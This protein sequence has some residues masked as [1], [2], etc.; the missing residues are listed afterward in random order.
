MKTHNRSV[1]WCLGSRLVKWKHTQQCMLENKAK[2]PTVQ[3]WLIVFRLLISCWW[4][5]GGTHL[6]TNEKT[7]S[8]LFVIRISL[9][10]WYL[11]LL[12]WWSNFKCHC[13]YGLIPSWLAIVTG[14]GSRERG[15]GGGGGGQWYVCAPPFNP[16]FL[17][18]TWIICLYKTDREYYTSTRWR[19]FILQRVVSKT[20]LTSES[21]LDTFRNH[22]L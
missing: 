4:L 14:V 10:I 3:S 21:E 17:F 9:I 5:L 12:S 13:L 2:Q 20:Y 22:E 7:R 18:F 11:F 19:R 16:I 15:G 6:E 1:Y 8:C